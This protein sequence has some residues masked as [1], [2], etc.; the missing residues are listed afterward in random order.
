MLTGGSEPDHKPP[1]ISQ[2]HYADDVLNWGD[3]LVIYAHISDAQTGIKSVKFEAYDSYFTY[4]T[5]CS[6]DMV[7][8]GGNDV[9]GDYE[10][11]C[12]IPSGA[13]DTYYLGSIY[14]YDGQNNV[15]FTTL[16]FKVNPSFK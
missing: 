11:S 12:V 6:G 15:G 14:A 4:I 1:V 7:L 8:T 5:I 2:A 13:D 9:S 16:S 3:T 10:Y